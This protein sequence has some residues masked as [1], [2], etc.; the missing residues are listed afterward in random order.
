MGGSGKGGTGVDRAFVEEHLSI[1]EGVA[2]G[3]NL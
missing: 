2:S 3:Q 1:F